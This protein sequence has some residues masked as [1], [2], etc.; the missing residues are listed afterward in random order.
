M[1]DDVE[2]LMEPYEDEVARLV[3]RDRW[4]EAVLRHGLVRELL[5]E[6]DPERLRIGAP[7][8]IGREKRGDSAFVAMVFDPREN[9]AVEVRGRLD[10]LDDLDVRPSAARPNPS[11]QEL[12][13]AAAVLREDPAFADFAGRDD[14][15]VYQPMPPLADLERDDGTT[16]RRIALGILDPVGSPRHRFVAVDLSDQVVDWDS[17]ILDHPDGD[18]EDHLPVGVESFDDAGGLAQV[19][20]RVLRGG[21]ELWDLVVVRPRDSTPTTY[22]KGSGVE[23]RFVRYRGRLVFWQAHVPILNVL[24]DDGVTFRDWQN[25]ETPFLAD[26]ADPVGAG[27]RLCTSPPATILEAGTDVGNFQGVALWYDEGELRIVSEVQ[28]G[29]YRYVS[30]WRLRDDGTIGPRF[31]FA[32]TRNP[33]TCMRHQHHV[34]WRLDFDIEGAGR[35][36][37][38]QRGWIVPGRSTWVRLLRET[39]RKRS[40]LARSWRVLDRETGRG[41][42]ITPGVTDGT[43]DAYGGADLWFLR[44][45]ATELDDGVSVVDGTPAD[46]QIQIGRYLTGESID[47]ADVVVWYA[48]H[49]VHDEEHPSPHQGHIVGPELRPIRW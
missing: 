49:F 39:S 5:G 42:A 7:E 37:V 3:P 34:Y 23:L 9:R 33:R 32:G 19:R 48:G 43:A 12:R 11:T 2:I 36:V 40:F 6:V 20:V 17:P 25:Q 8:V 28:A 38:Q 44:Y 1:P 35:D 21:E 14:V 22:G 4:R 13:D 15:V 46:T 10:A 31:G 29:W 45:R 24:Y 27:W 16:V 47:G 18:C 41:Y 30:D 26:G